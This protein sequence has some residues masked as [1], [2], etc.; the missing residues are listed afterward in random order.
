MGS[1]RFPGNMQ[2]PRSKVQRVAPIAAAAAAEAVVPASKHD[3]T[4]PDGATDIDSVDGDA[5][6]AD[7]DDA[8]AADA[9]NITVVDG[10]IDGVDA[11][12]DIATAAGAPRPATTATGPVTPSVY[13]CW[14]G[15]NPGEPLLTVRGGRR[16]S[17]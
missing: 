10:S 4:K 14:G 16:C 12:P 2:I 7:V 5:A 17:F 9:D 11:A 8:A 6:Q 15:I 3:S 13:R 1:V